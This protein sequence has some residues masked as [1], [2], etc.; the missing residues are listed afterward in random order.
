MSDPIDMLE[1]ARKLIPDIETG[2]PEELSKA[3]AEGK[4]K[5]I[6]RTSDSSALAS[7]GKTGNSGRL[8]GK[9]SPGSTYF[10]HEDGGI[11]RYGRFGK[12]WTDDRVSVGAKEAT[13]GTFLDEAVFTKE[14]PKGGIPS[15]ASYFDEGMAV[16]RDFNEPKVGLGLIEYDKGAAGAIRRDRYHEGH[17]VSDI[18]H[19]SGDVEFTGF[20]GDAAPRDS[21]MNIIKSNIEDVDFEH[22]INKYGKKEGFPKLKTTSSG[23]PPTAPPTSVAEDI[24]PTSTGRLR[25]TAVPNSAPPPPSP[26]PPPASGT[27]ARLRGTNITRQPYKFVDVAHINGAKFEPLIPDMNI[28]HGW[29]IHGD[30]VKDIAD[31]DQ[32][33]AKIGIKQ[34]GAIFKVGNQSVWDATAARLDKL[35][36]NTATDSDNLFNISEGLI[37]KKNVFTASAPSAPMING[38]P[39]VDMGGQYQ[40]MHSNPLDTID[41]MEVFDENQTQFKA[42]AMY[43][44]GREFTGYTQSIENR[45][46]LISSLE[47]R[48][49][50]RLEDVNPNILG[51]NQTEG[52]TQLSKKIT[53]RFT[54]EY[55]DIPSVGGVMDWASQNPAASKGQDAIDNVMA[56]NPQMRPYIHT[57]VIDDQSAA[58]LQKLTDDFPVFNEMLHG[59][60]GYVSPYGT[61]EDSFSQQG[62]DY[63]TGKAITQP[64]ATTTP[65]NPTTPQS[66]VATETYDHAADVSKATTTGESLVESPP[67]KPSAPEAPVAQP[68]NAPISQ[69]RLDALEEM[70]ASGTEAEREIAR[71]KLEELR[72]SG[73]A[74]RRGPGDLG[75]RVPIRTEPSLK[76]ADAAAPPPTGAS[77]TP[78][79]PTAAVTTDAP[80]T[81]PTTTTSSGAPPK[82]KSLLD[83]AAEAARNVARGHG[84]ARTLGIVG[85]ATLL[86]VGYATTRNKK[87]SPRDQGTYM[88][89][90]RRRL[91]Y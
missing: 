49:G 9:V 74:P 50:D 17:W 13:G 16:G 47:S 59:P 32:A 53:G 40:L 34:D 67:P 37:F 76:G 43:G 46:K 2:M 8:P 52:A 86:G 12:G 68:S 84:N 24:A 30:F 77:V 19:S 27:R 55:T 14:F 56:T 33:L 15:N 3:F 35:G 88:D 11:A 10:M 87:N 31:H 78:K 18:Y 23:L 72:R 7:F 69:R 64:T 38:R 75:T 5:T 82:T 70:A 28:N 51:G 39:V 57:G 73:R 41:M 48:L 79:T 66:A 61:I 44:E 21:D 60:N 42:S 36:I 80:K 45:D 85:A 91:G 25:G 54:T 6:F 71:K 63:K 89:E 81:S 65:V 1:L 83:D 22:R 90:S 62:Y 29:K 4:I 20:L 26:T 58:N